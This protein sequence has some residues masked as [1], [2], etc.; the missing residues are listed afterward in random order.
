MGLVPSPD[1]LWIARYV[2]FLG[3]LVV[4]GVAYLG[5]ALP[6]SDLKS[7]LP[8]IWAQPGGPLTLAGWL[9]GTGLLVAGWLLAGRST[10]LTLRWVLVTTA[11]WVAPLALAP[12]LGSRDVYAY[13]CQGAVHAAGLDA[14][15]VGPAQLPCPWL[16]S[17]STIWRET[18]APYGPLFVA[19]AAATVQHSL[20][21][22]VALLRVVAIAGVVLTAW[23]LPR[24]AAD[25]P[26]AA[27]LALATPPVSYTHLTL[28]TN[29][30][31]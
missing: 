29:R 12:P 26:R 3:A 9:V 1:Q 25:P 20:W 14:Y 15:A 23:A 19:I 5:G 7:D 30:E 11:L 27:W 18:P 10:Q 28:P 31:V 21:V 22:T 16:D 24:L 8:R 6:H 2:G 17:I 13:A 4:A